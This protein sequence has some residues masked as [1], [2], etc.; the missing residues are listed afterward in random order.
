MIIWGVH[1]QEVE[2][3]FLRCTFLE[4]RNKDN[5]AV[6]RGRDVCIFEVIF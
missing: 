5:V 2:L 4:K 1:Q 6:L 3:V